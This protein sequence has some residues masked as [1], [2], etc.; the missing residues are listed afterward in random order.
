[1]HQFIFHITKVAL[2]ALCAMAL[3]M[4]AVT[5]LP[6]RN[7]VTAVA[8][9]TSAAPGL[10]TAAPAAAAPGAIVANGA[11]T[12]AAAPA[13]ATAPADPAP[14][15]TVELR[16]GV[17]CA[18]GHRYVRV[19]IETTVRAFPTMRAKRAGSVSSL[20]KYMNQSMTA[21][22]QEVT[23]DGKW[24]RITVPWSKPVGATGWIP[25]E[26][27]RSRTT[28]ILLV[29]DLSERRLHVYDGCRERFSVPTAIGRPG[30]PSPQGSFWV[31]DRVAITG[32]LRSSYGSFAFG[33]STVQPNLP[34]GWTGGD[35]MAIH[36]T[37]APG[38]IGEAASAGCLRVGEAALQRLRPL[39]RTG[40]PVIIQA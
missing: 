23:P 39:L 2:L 11:P 4:A 27:L 18:Q 15:R 12:A 32:S 31:T 6:A 8:A 5:M 35:Q 19:P 34:R 33:L 10:A 28:K 26:G 13:P 16:G 17:E 29:E 30:S 38:S 25:L 3:G 24:G 37:G 20:S 36:G 22:V 40:T 14:T 9:E 21:W 1:M 7:G